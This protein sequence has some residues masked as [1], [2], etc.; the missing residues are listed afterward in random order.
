MSEPTVT[1][2]VSRVLR[3][4]DDF[5]RVVANDGKTIHITAPHDKSLKLFEPF[6]G[7]GIIHCPARMA[8]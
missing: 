1:V 2:K 5:V 6:T 8:Q 4:G 3:V 7:E